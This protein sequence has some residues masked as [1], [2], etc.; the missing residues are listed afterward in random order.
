[1]KRKL[2]RLVRKARRALTPHAPLAAT[3]HA[4]NGDLARNSGDWST[5]RDHYVLAVATCPDLE[6]IWV[7][8]GHAYKETDQPA[9]AEKAYKAALK[10]DENNADTWLQLGH[11]LKSLGRM[12]EALDAYEDAFRLEPHNSHAQREVL[13]LRGRV[14]RRRSKP[15]AIMVETIK[16]RYEDEAISPTRPVFFDLTGARD[17][18]PRIFNEMVQICGRMVGGGGG[19]ATA[20]IWSDAARA[21]TTL[22][23]AEIAEASLAR[24]VLLLS[25]PW[26]SVS[27]DYIEALRHLVLHHDT[28]LVSAF[29]DQQVFFRPDLHSQEHRDG[30]EI[31]LNLHR[32]LA[33]GALS[34]MGADN[35]RL[36]ELIGQYTPQIGLLPLPS[37]SQS[38][39]WLPSGP[40]AVF[41]IR[42]APEAAALRSALASLDV[43]FTDCIRPLGEPAVAATDCAGIRGAVFLSADAHSLS[44]AAACIAGGIP[45]AF[46]GGPGFGRLIDWAD[47]ILPTESPTALETSLAVFIQASV[48]GTRQISYPDEAAIPCSKLFAGWRQRIASPHPSKPEPVVFGSGN[49]GSS[50]AFSSSTL[51][52]GTWAADSLKGV[53]ILGESIELGHRP[54]TT[55]GRGETVALLISAPS[56]SISVSV[57]ASSEGPGVASSIDKGALAWVHC[58]LVAGANTARL[59]LHIR[60]RNP[61]ADGKDLAILH[62][63]FSY[64][65]GRPDVWWDFLDQIARGKHPRV[66]QLAHSLLTSSRDTVD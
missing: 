44:A 15:S 59:A 17:Q 58:P 36:R 65:T 46:T 20:V 1:M 52:P 16:P 53:R 37:A 57:S 42:G 64:P 2:A 62:S 21:W 24:S 26:A 9:E 54:Q 40:I 33:S 43:D 35:D 8:L 31:F 34:A 10:I 11:L 25:G 23:G 39:S 14:V 63:V 61:V 29:I 38:V 45:R 60:P 18:G 50:S 19:N 49:D 3:E 6:P 56:S 48:L 28:P 13:A 51:F 7:Q 47:A 66:R 5:A 22:D 32:T 27:D 12:T 4:R 41:G 30:A 55:S